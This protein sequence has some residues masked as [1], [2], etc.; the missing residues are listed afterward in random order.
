[1]RLLPVL[2]LAACSAERAAPGPPLPAPVL[3]GKVEEG[4]EMLGTKPPPLDVEWLDGEAH[5][6]EDDRGKVVLVRWW[7]DTC[8][9]CANSAKAVAALKAKHGDRLVVRAVYHEKVRGRRVDAAR[10][11][12]MARDVGFPYLVGIDRGWAALRRWWLDGGR[13][14][15]TSVSFLLGPDGR[16]AAIHT[17]G[18]FHARDQVAAD[19]CL[20]TPEACA[21]DYEALDRAI[22][23]LAR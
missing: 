7:T 14:S 1:M 15:Y 19:A 8:P 22:A 18:E 12:D 16:G 2:L 17:G 3:I 10:A 20:F 9:L 23:A 11:A 13:R 5:P 21:A 4:A 6:L